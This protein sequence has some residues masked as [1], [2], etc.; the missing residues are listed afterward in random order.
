MQ[1]GTK[2]LTHA[3]ITDTPYLDSLLL[4][5]KASG[6][7]REQLLASFPDTASHK[8]VT[9]YNQLL[10]IRETGKPIA[11]ILKHKEFYEH[12]FYVDERVLI[13][14]PDTEL[15]VETAA[16]LYKHGLPDNSILD[17]CTGS[18]CIGIS[19][20]AEF[21]DAA[22][23]LGDI[24][25]GALEVCRINSQRILGAELPIYQSDLLESIPGPFSLIVSNPPYLTV[26]EC[27]HPDLLHRGEPVKALQAGSDGL[28]IIRRLARQGFAKLRKKGYLI[29][30]CGFDQALLV[31]EIMS[32]EGFTIKE[33]LKDLAGCDRVVIGSV[34]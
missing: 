4:L 28:D 13:P 25:A 32:S 5:C 18:G 10:Q 33:I 12:D 14:R 17:I 16:N 29:T 6:E 24:S 7:T 27:L 30:E 11:Y 34:K 20:K 2:T 31:S 3:G 26:D 23:T 9:E 19:L 21:P 1:Q 15:L 8:T 22:V